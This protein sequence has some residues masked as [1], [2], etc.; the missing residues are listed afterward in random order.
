ML[1]C[2]DTCGFGCNGGEPAFAWEYFIHV[3]V[4]SG[5]L[6]N[7]NRWCRPYHLAPCDHHT[8]GQYTNCS[9][10]PDLPT[11]P[12]EFKCNNEFKGTYAND[13]HKCKIAY[14]IS[15][16]VKAIQTELMNNGPAEASI[17]VY[18][19]F[20]TYKSGV[21]YHVTG[22]NLG[23][24]SIK[25]LGWGVENGIEYWLCANSWN[26]DWGEKGYFR[27]KRGTNE[28]GIEDEIVAGIP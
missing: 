20:M 9:D 1:T 28:C 10:T 27:I 6:Y 12:C 2:C 7:D 16:N 21:Y 26:T 22:K 25:I 8:S 23:G 13:L 24:H 19:D 14:T 3:G 5:G 4:S 17:T 11:T 18:E 15:K